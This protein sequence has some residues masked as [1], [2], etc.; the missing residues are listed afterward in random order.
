MVKTIGLLMGKVKYF[1]QMIY[2]FVEKHVLNL[3]VHV[4]HLRKA[5]RGMVKIV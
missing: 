4:L 5:Q 2:L 3:I 1:V